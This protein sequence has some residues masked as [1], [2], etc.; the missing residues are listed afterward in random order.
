MD[1]R[2]H[3]FPRL[4]FSPQWDSEQK[5][6]SPLRT[7]V[8]Q[9]LI[10][11]GRYVTENFLLTFP[12]RDRPAFRRKGFR[13]LADSFLESSAV[14]GSKMSFWLS[15]DIWHP[16]QVLR[17]SA[18][19]MRN[20]WYRSSWNFS[21]SACV[22]RMKGVVARVPVW[23]WRLALGRGLALLE[24]LPRREAWHGYIWGIWAFKR[25]CQSPYIRRESP[26]TTSERCFVQT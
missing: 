2:L 6:H 24:A 16:R 4:C 11:W 10:P 17:G 26:E 19:V 22:F 8:D 5:P 13:Y 21:I 25:H 9:Y 3:P 23:S 18:N 12:T 15:W 20:N 1:S 14:W 7:G